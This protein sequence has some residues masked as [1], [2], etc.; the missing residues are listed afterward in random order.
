MAA[1]I[2]FL[3]L[4]RSPSSV[5]LQVDICELNHIVSSDGKVSVTYWVW[6]DYGWLV[7]HGWDYYV[8]DWRCEKDAPFP[9]GNRQ[10]W[11]DKRTHKHLVVTHRTFRETWSNYDP[12]T[13]DRVRWPE[14]RR[15][16]F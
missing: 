14:D 4:L 2:L 7:E 3:S 15:R 12:E 5:D 16:K 1:V 6:W 9:I 13:A 8:R 11:D 10:E